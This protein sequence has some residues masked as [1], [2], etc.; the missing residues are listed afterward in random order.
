MRATRVGAVAGNIYS[1]SKRN[2][3]AGEAFTLM[4]EGRSLDDFHRQQQ[5]Q[6]KKKK[7]SVQKKV[8]V[9]KGQHILIKGIQFEA[10]TMAALRN[11]LLRQS[12]QVN[13]ISKMKRRNDTYR[14]SI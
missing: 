12:Q 10:D 13:Y 1:K 3:E 11:Q 6:G 9:N 5:K 14:T 2:L 4:N 8:L 7:P